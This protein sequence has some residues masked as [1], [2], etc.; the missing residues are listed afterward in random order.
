MVRYL[1]KKIIILLFSLLFIVTL[2][3]ILMKVIPGDP[4]IQEQNVP[5]EILNSLYK[6]YGLDQPIYIQYLKYIKGFLTFD[7][8]PS[9][10]YE[11]RTVNQIIYEGFPVSL[12][13]GVQAL[14]IAVL[15][16]ITLGCIAA[17]F[18]N[19]LEDSVCLLLSI[20]LTA[21]PT[22]LLA[23]LLQYV[24]AMKLNL[25]PV[26]Q[27]GSFSHCILP[28]LS[29]SGMPLA[30]IARLTRTNMVEILKQDYIK[31]ALAKG[32]PYYKI[33]IKHALR[34]ALIPILAYLGHVATFI[35][36]GSFVIEKIFAISGLGGWLISSI[37][38]RDY[39]VIMGLTV[40]YSAFLLLLVFFIDLSYALLDPRIKITKK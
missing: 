23:T 11:G 2:T 20:F 27:W 33:I 3:F 12:I 39:T 25:L 19:K 22:F 40:F 14:F 6:H 13:L 38:N 31:T 15:F 36:T 28:V 34:N 9:F 18:Q 8:G 24:F 21:I 37:M 26:A 17:I 5:E 7:L 30:F 10:L 4:F 1:F 16:G 35:L 29:L 32:L